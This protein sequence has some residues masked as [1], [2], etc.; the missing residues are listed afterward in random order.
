MKLKEKDVNRFYSKITKTQDCWNWTACKTHFGYGHFRLNGKMVMAHRV[1][2]IDTFGE[3]SDGL[4]ILHKC[5]NPSC[6]NPGHLFLG[7][8]AD[9]ARDREQKGRS[10]YLLIERYKAQATC[11]NGHQYDY[12]NSKG[13]RICRLCRR[14]FLKNWRHT[15]GI[16][17]GYYNGQT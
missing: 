2:W 11:S 3:I 14:N 10:R 8:Y 16:S 13:H 12:V 7:D 1:S 6:V 15:K 9:N 5:D 17:K 4:S